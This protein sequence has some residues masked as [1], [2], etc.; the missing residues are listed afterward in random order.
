MNLKSQISNWKFAAVSLLLACLA[1]T[2][3]NTAPRYA[4][5]ADPIIVEAERL[6]EGALDVFDTFLAWERRNEAVIRERFPDVHQFAETLRR[7]VGRV[8]QAAAW[9]DAL[10]EAKAR[11]KAT[12]T[13][14]AL[15][16]LRAAQAILDVALKQAALYQTTHKALK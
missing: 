9:I 11:Y 8:P 7:P 14:D 3:C 5:G 2:G 4:P 1:L 15:N 10:L 12:R 16:S 13:A 6:A